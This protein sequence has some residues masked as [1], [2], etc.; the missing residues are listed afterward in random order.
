MFPDLA[1]MLPSVRLLVQVAVVPLAKV[2]NAR[3]VL[4]A[5]GSET[6]DSEKCNCKSGSEGLTI[7][8]AWVHHFIK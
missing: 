2:S 7:A 6:L 3:L 4:D 8:H 5:C 1:P